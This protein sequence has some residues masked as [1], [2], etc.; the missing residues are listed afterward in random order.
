MI[1]ETLHKSMAA[2]LTFLLTLWPY[3]AICVRAIAENGVH[4]TTQ[5][6][7]IKS[8]LEANFLSSCF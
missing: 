4:P 5:I 7:M 3:P 6:M 8:S 2:R 1:E